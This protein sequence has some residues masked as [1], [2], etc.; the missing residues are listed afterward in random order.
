MTGLIIATQWFA[1]PIDIVGATVAS[2]A[3]GQA[4]LLGIAVLGLLSEGQRQ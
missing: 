3:V 2:I 1:G 4:A